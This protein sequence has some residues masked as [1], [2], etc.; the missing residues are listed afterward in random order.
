M[1]VVYALLSLR[2][3]DGLQARDS[4]QLLQDGVQLSVEKEAPLDRLNHVVA[5]PTAATIAVHSGLLS[6]KENIA[7]NYYLSA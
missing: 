4:S 7:S 6:R 3:L 1:Q 2:E 5:L